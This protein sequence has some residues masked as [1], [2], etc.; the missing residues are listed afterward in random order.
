MK[1]TSLA[2][3][4]S[5]LTEDS[6]RER[7]RSCILENGKQAAQPRKWHKQLP[8]VPLVI[9]HN[10]ESD[11]T[12]WVLIR[13]EGAFECYS[14][15]PDYQPMNLPEGIQ[16]A[17]EVKMRYSSGVQWSLYQNLAD[18]LK[19]KDVVQGIRTFKR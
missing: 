3:I 1:I 10:I 15:L 19:H 8:K 9:G 17:I 14:F 7:L 18:T 16:R 13:Y 4:E 11:E 2:F 5:F 6:Q 12:I